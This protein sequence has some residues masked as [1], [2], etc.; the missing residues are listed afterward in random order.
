MLYSF[1]SNCKRSNVLYGFKYERYIPS[2]KLWSRIGDEIMKDKNAVVKLWA[3]GNSLIMFSC[4]G[5]LWPMHE[6]NIWFYLM[7]SIGFIGS[8]LLVIK[9]T[10]IR[11]HEMFKKVALLDLMFTGIPMTVAL[12]VKHLLKIN[13]IESNVTLVLVYGIFAI[14]IFI[15]ENKLRECQK[16]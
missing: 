3:L 4:S 15:I 9:L 7:C 10:K 5:H 1:T 14:G 12:F 16:R 8:L 11:K 2:Y 13:N 6:D